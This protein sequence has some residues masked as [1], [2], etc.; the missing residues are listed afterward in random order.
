VELA[1]QT[2]LTE[3][4]TTQHKSITIDVN[5]NNMA[6]AARNRDYILGG[7]NLRLRLFED[8]GAFVI[9]QTPYVD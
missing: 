5:S 8:I 2:Q 6:T 1:L 4:V 9:N 3:F 7:L